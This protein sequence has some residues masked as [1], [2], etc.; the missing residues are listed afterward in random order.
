M[1]TSERIEISDALTAANI[2]MERAQ[3]LTQTILD[4]YF[5]NFDPANPKNMNAICFVFPKMRVLM[6]LLRDQLDAIDGALPAVQWVDALKCDEG[7]SV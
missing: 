6:G 7:V 4:D 2:Y 3:T 1:T 5:E